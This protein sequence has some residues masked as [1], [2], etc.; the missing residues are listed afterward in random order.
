MQTA[1]LLAFL[2]ALMASQLLHPKMVEIAKLKHITDDPNQR[3][4]QRHP[5][6]VLG[7]LVVFF[8]IIMGAGLTTYAISYHDAALYISMMLLMLTVG[9][10]DD[11]VNLTP[12]VRFAVE[13]GATLCL[14]FLGGIA[15]DDF[16]GLWGL[17]H[18]GAWI[19][20]P[21]TII[22]VVGIINAINL[23]DGV[24]GLSSG[25]CI[26]ACA[27]FGWYFYTVG[28]MPMTAL[29]CA[30]AGSLIPFFI[31]NVFGHK[32]KMFIGDGGTLLMGMVLSIMVLR[33][34]T[35]GHFHIAS[36]DAE[37]LMPLW[38]DTLAGDR[39][40]I[41]GLVP[42]TLA[43]LSFPICDTLRVMISRVLRHQSP[44][45]PDKTHLHHAFIEI[46][47]NH[48]RTTATI[49]TLNIFIFALWNA[50]YLTGCSVD[51]QFYAV[52]GT[53]IVLN[54]SIYYGCQRIAHHRH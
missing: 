28:D 33:I 48:L 38:P 5:V 53:T 20:I 27:M 50:L 35:P 43:V 29:A 52:V 6:P 15:V 8:G 46:G 49:L 4:L 51:T 44:F 40:P 18:V 3:K 2:I 7:G 26:V 12:S 23:I 10:V 31:H 13:I 21:L 24:D 45:S 17:R 19:S 36:H 9:T 41:F 32:S 34:L 11:V 47:F 54:L 1:L 30:S 16:Y 22:T 42:F 39:Q 14:I 37:S 25:Y